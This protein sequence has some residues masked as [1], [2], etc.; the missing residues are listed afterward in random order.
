MSI[1][2]DCGLMDRLADDGR[3][4]KLDDSNLPTGDHLA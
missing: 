4:G 2:K 3:G 1:K